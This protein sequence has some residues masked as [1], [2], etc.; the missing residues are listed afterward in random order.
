MS[1][2]IKHHSRDFPMLANWINQRCLL[3]LWFLSQLEFL[4]SMLGSALVLVRGLEK[5]SQDLVS[6]PATL[7]PLGQGRFTMRQ[8]FFSNQMADWL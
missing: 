1:T 4:A 5:L 6:F 2:T 3:Q 8:V 7:F